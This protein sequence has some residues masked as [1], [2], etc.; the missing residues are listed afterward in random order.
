MNSQLNVKAF[1]QRV[2]P[3]NEPTFNDD[4]WNSLDFVVN[5]VDNIKARL[6]IDNLC[7]WYGKS[8]FESGTLG[9][10]CNTQIIIPKMS[11]PYGETNDPNEDTIPLCTLKNFPHQIEHTIEWARDYFE[12]VLVEDPNETI[13]F[14]QNPKQYIEKTKQLLSNSLP[15]LKDRF[16]KI[17]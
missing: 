15:A 2:D 16:A 4:F 3:E 12:Q 5:A 7:V 9:T 14:L 1:Q 11:Q 10:K 8:L 13:K 17:K 6:Y